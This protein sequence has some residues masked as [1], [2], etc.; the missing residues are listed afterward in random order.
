MTP[1]FMKL[2]AS[3]GVEGL[4]DS[5][6]AFG[7]QCMSDLEKLDSDA[8]EG[9]SSR[10]D[11]RARGKVGQTNSPASSWIFLDLGHHWLLLTLG[12]LSYLNLS[13]KSPCRPAEGLPV[14]SSTSF[15][16]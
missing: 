11:R 2:D 16:L 6:R 1:Q 10:G 5:W 12:E 3:T 7:L 13:W 14:A 4:K 15:R 8:S 9:C